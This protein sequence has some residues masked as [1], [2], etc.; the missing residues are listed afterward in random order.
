VH[1]PNVDQI[2]FV[3]GVHT[4]RVLPFVNQLRMSSKRSHFLHAYLQDPP[5]DAPGD[6][7]RAFREPPH[8]LVEELFG[9]DLQMYGVSA[10][11]DEVIEDGEREEGLVWISRIDVDEQSLGRFSSAVK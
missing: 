7:R 2:L 6:H 10:V 4:Q 3:L 5:H 8:E 1:V 11:L 9:G